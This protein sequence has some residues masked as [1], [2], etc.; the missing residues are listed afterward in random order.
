[1]KRNR[2]LAIT[3]G[4][5]LAGLTLSVLSYGK[6]C[7]TKGCSRLHGAD[8]FGLSLEVWGGLLFLLLA[9]LT[10]WT[11]NPWLNALRRAVLAGAVGA[12]VTLLYIQW[13]MP[14]VC[15][16]CLAVSTVVLALVVMEVIGMAAAAR[17]GAAA[18]AQ[19]P[20]RAQIA[21]WS[22]LIAA[23]LIAGMVV[24]QPIR[25]ELAEQAPR[26]AEAGE[27]IPG[28]GQPG[29]YPILRIYSDY[30][31]PAC[32]QQEPVLNAVVGEAAGKARVVFCDL[33][34]HGTISKMYIAYFIACLLGENDDEQLLRARK[35]LFEMAGEKVQTKN[36]LEA[37]LRECG[38]AIQLEGEAI[39]QCYRLIRQAAAQ[40]GVTHTPTVVIENEK[41]DKRVFKGRFTR[42]ELI[43]ALRI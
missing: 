8:L 40:D 28:V 19:P 34:T 4:L 14:E 41:G 12:E 36:Q 13:A 31:C 32:R 16:L 42:D 1:M 9:V 5:I 23:G 17:S 43:E 24:T 29:G 21:G 3:Y 38:V 27:V 11:R 18:S 35:C 33:P 26:A 6:W 20:A 39:N 7:A 10:P 15:L 25:S 37:A 2:F 22:A 30:F